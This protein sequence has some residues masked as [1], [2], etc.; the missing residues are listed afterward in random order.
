VI[1]SARD[2]AARGLALVRAGQ[3]HE[4]LAHLQAALAEIDLDPSDYD[5]LIEAMRAAAH[6]TQQPRVAASLDWYDGRLEVGGW[7]ATPPNDLARTHRLH[8]NEPAAARA[9]EEAGLLAHAAVAHERARD[10]NSARACW[11]RLCHQLAAPDPSLARRGPDAT[12]ERSYILGLARYDVARNAG[13]DSSD[14]RSPRDRAHRDAVVAA[15]SAL[16][17]AAQRFE[18]LGLR[19]RAFDCFNALS[20]IGETSGTFEHVLEGRVNAI[21]ILREDYLQQYALQ[22]Y[23]EAIELSAKRDEHAAA[24]S[25]AREAMAYAAALGLAQDATAYARRAVDLHVAAGRLLLERGP[26]ELAENAFLAAIALAAELGL[27]AR[28]RSLY[29]ELAHA[30]PLEESR[31]AR[32]ERAAARLD[33]AVDVATRS[34]ARTPRPTGPALEVW[35]LDVIEWE[36]SG[37]A[38]DACAEVLFDVYP[39]PRGGGRARELL[40]TPIRRRALVA[41][42][43]ALEVERLGE[44]EPARAA[45]ARVELARRLGE[46]VDY[47]MLAPLE[48]L[49]RDATPEVRVRAVQA[50]ANLPFKRSAQLLREAAR[51]DDPRVVSAAAAALDRK[52][53]P[54]FVDPLR[55]LSRDANSAE[56]RVAALRTLASI[57]NAE[58]AEAVVSALETGTSGERAAI[59]EALRERRPGRDGR[60]VAT[61]RARLAQGVAPDVAVDLQRAIGA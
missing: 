54:V 20:A 33:G 17:D 57:D 29:S 13:R 7:Q 51:D 42:L 12:A 53:S 19:E 43:V 15:V 24:A 60:L 14:S 37:R 34:D 44:A 9:F 6:A 18:A 35:I 2:A 40:H 30:K 27:L 10:S 22:Q 50:A 47:R 31:R 8:G 32:H 45:G 25:F 38:A 5:A 59:L 28:A 52:R 36:Q 39:L 23:D 16:E 58:A 26:A 11:A 46:I 41:R 21:R 55:R 61:L 49:A 1:E 56:V 4:G 3:V 48:A